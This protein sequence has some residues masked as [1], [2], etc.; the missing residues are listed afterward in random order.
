M[1]QQSVPTLGAAP[2]EVVDRLLGTLPSLSPQL[3]KAARF[4]L[5][6]PREVGI[7]SIGELAD[8][9]GVKPNTLVRMARA[10]GFE[11]YEGFREPFREL[12][13]AGHQD[14]PDRARWLQAVAREG[15]HG[16]LLHKMAVGA[17]SN[18][19]SLFAGVTAEAVKQ[20]ADQIVEARATYVLGVGVTHG[21]V[22]NFAYLADMA[23]ETV[24]AIPREGSV[25]MDD[26]ARA[27]D[28]DVL[29][30]VTFAP[31][32]AEV[33]EAVRAARAQ[34]LKVVAVTDGLSS[35]IALEAEHVF[36]VPTES[37]QFFTSIVAL[38]ALFETLMA[39]VIADASDQ[40]VESI[41]RFH[42]RRSALGVY[43]DEDS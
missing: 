24:V 5:D 12:I 19:E 7:S 13:R 20:A 9:A 2:P 16:E 36:C 41:E 33:V 1:E 37:P 34:G 30:A 11:G 17:M 43:W 8:A 31:Y 27:G 28:G 6:N 26:L 42:R 18:V 29:V 23:L 38:S 10:V 40:V 39:F 22:R 21:V 15:Q 3:R 14:F 32:R 4:V 35:P 25:A